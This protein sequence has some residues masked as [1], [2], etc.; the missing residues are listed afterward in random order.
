MIVGLGIDA[1]EIS[2]F[3]RWKSYSLHQLKRVFSAQE[4]AYC[5]AQPNKSAERLAARFAAREAFYK[6]LSAA[7]PD[8]AMPFLTVCAKIAVMNTPPALAVDWDYLSRAGVTL[9]ELKTH[10]S[11]THTGSTAIAVVILEA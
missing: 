8:F 10:L 5:L 9:P 2:R 7:A 6:A 4:I 11:L 3:E 1:V